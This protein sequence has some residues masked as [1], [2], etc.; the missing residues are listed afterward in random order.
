M[1]HLPYLFAAFAVAWLG[2]FLYLW[3]LRRDAQRLRNDLNA[4]TEEGG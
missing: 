1:G 3:T 2:I 4:L